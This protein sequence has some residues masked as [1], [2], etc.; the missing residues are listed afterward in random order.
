MFRVI[1]DGT[2]VGSYKRAAMAKKQADWELE[3]GGSYCEIYR[4]KKL[5]AYRSWNGQWR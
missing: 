3:F 2:E 1:V 5:Y 4:C